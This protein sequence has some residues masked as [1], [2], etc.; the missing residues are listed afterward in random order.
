M[1]LEGA[2]VPT[3]YRASMEKTAL[4]REAMM[5]MLEAQFFS[6]H[7]PWKAWLSAAKPGAPFPVRILVR[8]SCAKLWAMWTFEW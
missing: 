1:F 7:Q 6:P 2:H 8:T 4:L 3:P 5:D